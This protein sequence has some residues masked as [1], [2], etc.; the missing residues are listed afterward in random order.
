MKKLMVLTVAALTAAS[1]L[2]APTTTGKK[3]T[4]TSTRGKSA[5]KAAKA[6]DEPVDI[7]ASGQ[8]V[9]VLI[10]RRPRLG[11]LATFAA[12]SV[13][14]ATY[15]SGA[16]TRPRK[17]IVLE[18]QYSML[19]ADFVDQLT[20]TW[21]VLLD[22]ST[23]T[24]NRSN[25]EGLPPYSYFTTAVTYQNIA[26]GAHAASVVLAPSYLERYGD[27]CAV[28]LEVTDSQGKT[29]A[30]GC[31]SSISFLA[32][33]WGNSADGPRKE[34]KPFFWQDREGVLDKKQNG[35][36]MVRQRQGLKDRSKTIWALVNPNDYEDV[37]E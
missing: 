23:S 19:G 25:K 32:A 33:D 35:A 10:D 26:E 9:R 13:N 16:W 22:V 28:G 5:A 24:L 11:K 20:F 21:H 30:W 6:A 14:G 36:P 34:S 31:E 12:P 1:M 15:V 7:S 18:T 27:P 8:G 4:S 3:G 29:V 17:W 2:A 37:A